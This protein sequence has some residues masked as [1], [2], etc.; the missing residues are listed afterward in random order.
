MPDSARRCL[1]LA[2]VLLVYGA[3][4]IYIWVVRYHYRWAAWV[5]LG[6]ILVSQ[7]IIYRDGFSTLG[8]R[9]D[10]LWPAFGETVRLVW[11]GLG[12]LLLAVV[13]RYW[14]LE[15]D[16]ARGLRPFPVF[17]FVSAFV[18]Q[19]V[20]QGFFHRRLSRIFPNS[21]WTPLLVALIFSTLHT[22]N[23]PLIV[24]TFVAGFYSAWLFRRYPNLIPLSLAHAVF[25]TLL[26]RSLPGWLIRN[27]RVG[28]GYYLT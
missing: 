20:L 14:L 24:T 2:E 17:Y 19:Y 11:P 8:L 12:V 16:P 3:I 27:M 1:I 10:N 25:G 28:P 23:P 7:W 9:L 26:A 6:W 5:I 15:P 13:V 21:G 22:P 18:Q 4:T